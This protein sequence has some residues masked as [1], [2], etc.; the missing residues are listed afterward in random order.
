MS[1][2][3]VDSD[4]CMNLTIALLRQLKE[5]GNCKK[6]LRWLWVLFKPSGSHLQFPFAYSASAGAEKDLIESS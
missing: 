1:V 2:S 4:A 5:L 3:C 6:L